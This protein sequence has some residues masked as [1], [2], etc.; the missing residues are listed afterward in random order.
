MLFFTTVSAGIN[1]GFQNILDK[2]SGK[3]PSEYYLLR[4]FRI[5]DV[6]YLDI[7][8]I[9]RIPNIPYD[10]SISYKGR[11]YLY[12]SINKCNSINDLIKPEKIDSV[13]IEINDEY[14]YINDDSNYNCN[15]LYKIDN[16]T[17]ILIDNINNIYSGLT[18]AI[19]NNGIK[20]IKL[21]KILNKYINDNFGFS[22]YLFFEKNRNNYYVY[23]G[24]DEFFYDNILDA[25]FIRDGRLIFIYNINV[26]KNGYAL[27]D[28]NNIYKNK[29][30]IDLK[31]SNNV[32]KFDF[33]S[34]IKYKIK[35]KHKFKKIKD[36]F[37]SP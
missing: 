32:F 7:C 13:K 22:Y 19:S 29:K 12:Y 15:Q 34:L 9:K 28:E 6:D 17:F 4:F 10:G 27:F 25:Y 21:S 30:N 37:M 33:L 24:M 26:L 5:S 8:R 16:D 35:S 36:P 14:D 2:Y 1:K 23:I 11:T 20:N 18:K 3:Y 31:A